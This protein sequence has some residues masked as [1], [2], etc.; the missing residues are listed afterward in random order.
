MAPLNYTKLV[1]FYLLK[2]LQ[3]TQ[4]GNVDILGIER[5]GQDQRKKIGFIAAAVATTLNKKMVLLW[6]L[7]HLPRKSL[8]KASNSLPIKSFQHTKN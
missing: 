8:A 4:N 5:F 6:L 3:N 2:L 7:Q 1:K